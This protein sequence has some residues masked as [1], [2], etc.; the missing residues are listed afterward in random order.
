MALGNMALGRLKAA[1]G[2]SRVVF[3]EDEDGEFASDVA[4]LDL[5]D[6]E[7]LTV[8]GN[9][10]AVKRRVLLDEPDGR[11]LVYRA[12]GAPTPAEDF[13]LDV[14]LASASFSNS[15]AAEW[16][17]ECGIPAGLESLLEAHIALM[18]IPSCTACLK[19]LFASSIWL[20]GDVVRDDV[21]LSLLAAACGIDDAPQRVDARRKAAIAVVKGYALG[22]ASPW[23]AIVLGNLEDA[24][25]RELR[26]GFGYLAEEPSVAD[27]SLACVTSAC[28]DLTGDAPALNTE[29][30]VLMSEMAQNPSHRRAFEELMLKEQG[31]LDATHDLGSIDRAALV[32][33]P[34]LPQADRLI[35]EG[36]AG[37]VANGVDCAEE[38]RGIVAK[39]KFTPWYAG[40]E[41]SYDALAA[42]NSLIDG[43]RRFD[44]ERALAENAD[45]IVSRYAE[46]WHIID[47][48]YRRFHEALE[49]DLLFDASELRRAVEPRYG[50]FLSDLATMWQEQVL[51]SKA[52]PPSAGV[53]LQRDFFKEAVMNAYGERVAV[54][55][56]DALRY[57]AGAE[58]AH[59]LKNGSPR[60][61]AALWPMV[62]MA[63]TYTQLGMAALLPGRELSIDVATQGATVD[64]MSAT[65]ID[66][67]ERILA[68]GDLG[69]ACV[70]SSDLLPG[71]FAGQEQADLLYVYHNRIDETGDSAK[72][73]RE[74]FR[75]TREAFGE[76]RKLVRLL[77]AQ[78][79]DTVLITADHG[80]LYQD[81]DPAGFSYVDDALLAIAVMAGR[82]SR[83]RRFALGDD[84]PDN[85]QMMRFSAGQLGLAGDFDVWIP[86]G[87]RRMRLQGSGARFVHGG[88]TLQEALVPVVSVAGDATPKRRR[89]VGVQVLKGGKSVITG[90][91]LRVKLYQT[92]PVSETRTPLHLRVGLYDEESNPASTVQQLD[93]T[94]EAADDAA[95]M[96][97]VELVLS[98]GVQ[99]GAKLTLKVEGRWGQ[100]SSYTTRDTAEYKVRRSFGMDF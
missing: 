76:I 27:F 84:L 21:E 47:G 95:R 50:R 87:I 72:S 57:E 85:D 42:A 10:F 49:R 4:S 96:T 25:W 89:P 81:G 29:A 22:A 58:L 41:A 33:N 45:Q 90:S 68:K 46:E 36:L 64:G 44:D 61:Q 19:E 88:M 40:A 1:F 80:F 43:C 23:D 83:T 73:E 63:P 16:A 82:G 39:R 11:F 37:Q 56:S 98:A 92:E 74:V 12:G 99:H 35:V 75:A 7:V 31:F 53:A 100:T 14:K 55:I 30:N 17:Q 18:G 38:I 52:W 20:E 77:L 78:D 54:I 24:L 51:A 6:A 62:A 34:Y 59:L 86:K 13:L 91:S 32:G 8:D 69:G 71:G 28:C 79:Y 66:N 94:S 70:Q 93:L 3:W 60:Y 65:G 97:E 2:N 15:R 9:A 48:S 26:L 5:G 67:R